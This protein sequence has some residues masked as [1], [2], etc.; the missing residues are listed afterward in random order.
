V[1]CCTV[2]AVAVFNNLCQQKGEEIKGTERRRN[3]RGNEEG[4]RGQAGRGG[5]ERGRGGEEMGREGEEIGRGETGREDESGGEGREWHIL[6]GEKP[7]KM[8]N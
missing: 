7:P 3:K 5:E 4:S 2:L 6:W 1:I 8:Q